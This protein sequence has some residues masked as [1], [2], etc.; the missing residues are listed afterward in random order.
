MRHDRVVLKF[1]EKMGNG[2]MG[3]F[4]KLL[5]GLILI[6]VIILFVIGLIT[7]WPF[8]IG[9]VVGLLLSAQMYKILDKQFQ[10]NLPEMFFWG[11]GEIVEAAMSDEE[12][13][14]N[15]K[16]ELKQKKSEALIE[17]EKMEQKVTNIQKAHMAMKTTMKTHEMVRK[18]GDE[19][20]IMI[21]MRT[22]KAI[23]MQA[24]DQPWIKELQDMKEDVDWSKFL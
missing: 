4:F 3:F 8:V 6:L 12:Q 1:L 16:I 19:R 13:I 23:M 2:L 5:F 20:K 21:G 22:K 10:L 11:F 18:T 14:E 24:E 15:T 7:Y 17:L 9:L